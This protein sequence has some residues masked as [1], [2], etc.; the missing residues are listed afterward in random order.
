VNLHA[1]FIV[2]SPIPDQGIGVPCVS[3]NG[4][5]KNKHRNRVFRVLEFQPSLDTVA[6]VREVF[7]PPKKESRQ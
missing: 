5:E 6:E 3:A 4:D 2:P 7:G 1:V